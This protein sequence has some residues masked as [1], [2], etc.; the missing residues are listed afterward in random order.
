[1]N[2]TTIT[3]GQVGP[4]VMQAAFIVEDVEAAAKAW[5]AATGIGPFFMVP[6]RKSVV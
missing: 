3:P 5:I 4:H 2:G 6:D 1:M